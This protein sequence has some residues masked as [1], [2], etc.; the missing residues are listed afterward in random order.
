MS[1]KSGQQT[2]NTPKIDFILPESGKLFFEQNPEYLFCKPELMPLK[3]MTLEK[4]ERMQKQAREQMQETRA[5]TA[6]AKQF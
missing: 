3:S 1:A 6:A 4:L 5:R 2:P